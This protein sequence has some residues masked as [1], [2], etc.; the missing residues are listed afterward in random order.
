M[1]K[2]YRIMRR[3]GSKVEWLRHQDCNHFWTQKKDEAMV[4]TDLGV[5]TALCQ[6][7]TGTEVQDSNS[8][9]AFAN[10]L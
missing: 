5:A 9:T 8:T 4:Y 2:E 10:Q 6:Q 7:K 3:S 1:S